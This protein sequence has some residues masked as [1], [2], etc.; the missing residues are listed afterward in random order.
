MGFSSWFKSRAQRQLDSLMQS[1]AA[2]EF[3]LKGNILWA[4]EP[5]LSLMGYSLADIKGQHHSRFVDPAL[6]A[7]TEYRDF[8][9]RL[10]AGQTQTAEFMRLTKRGTPVWLQASYIPVPDRWGQ[11]A[12]VVK[13]AQDT[14]ERKL[15]DAYFKGQIEAIGKSQ[16]VIEFD[17]AGHILHAN[18]N[19]LNTLGY[20]L[21]EVVGKHHR[22]FV[23]RH[24]AQGAS[25][26]A[27]WNELRAGHFR[28]AEF[29]RVHKSGRDVWIQASYNPI[30]DF[31]GQPQRVV[32]FATDVTDVV[33]QRKTNELLSLVANGT[34]SS[35]VICSADG[36]CEYVNPGFTKLTGYSSEEIMGK[37]PGQLL[38]GKHTDPA[39]VDRIR[40]SLAA[41]QPF[42]EQVLNY[43]KQGEP[44]WISLAINPIYGTDGKLAHFVSVQ[45]NVTVSKMRAVEDATRLAAIRAST[46]TADW[47]GDGRL[48]DVSPKLL[49]LLGC[50][51]VDGATGALSEMYADLMRSSDGLSAESARREVKAT[52]LS[53]ETLSL[54]CTFNAILAV[55]GTLSKVSMYATDMTQQ[56]HMIERIR[57]VVGTINGL[58]MQTN[59]LSLNAAIEAARAGEGG[60]GFAVVAS[61]VRNLARRS[62]DSASEIAS[63]LQH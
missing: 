3:D 14:T 49:A 53:G 13:I 57:T 32:K 54:D 27:F 17:M 55:D 12:R 21:P 24:E 58:A 35:V 31:N 29:R 34:D 5:F 48:L 36:L 9:D 2:I 41:Q 46:A 52:A 47:S 8:W 37:K 26:E 1:Q 50:T 45:S 16:A 25:Y 20:T 44:Y 51:D 18:D 19:F 30:F 59:L 61:E 40:Q 4:N 63:M 62:A 22:L 28:S 56:R 39:T 15:R 7:N 6:A 23:D 10:R 11:P 43:T 60:R 42:Y 33:L 38:Q